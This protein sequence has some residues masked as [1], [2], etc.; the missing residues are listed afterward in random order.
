MSPLQN[1]PAQDYETYFVPILFLPWAQILLDT[2]KPQPGERLLDVACGTGIVAR[3]AAPLVGSQGKVTGVDI[4]PG[5]LNVARTFAA[6][7]GVPLEWQEGSAL[8]L[9][10]EDNSYNVIVC[11]QGLQFFP[12]KLKALQE[13]LR[14]LVPGGRVVISVNQSLAHN[15]LYN[16]FNQAFVQHL[17]APAL[18]GP[19]AFGD[20]QQLYALLV[21]AG[22]TQAAVDVVSLPIHAESRE[23][24]VRSTVYGSAAV[25]PALAQLDD[26]ARTTLIEKVIDAM[27]DPFSAYTQTGQLVFSVA[28]N[29]GYGTKLA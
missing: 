10:F 6:S 11:Q 20:D 1:N 8:S 28:A 17:G 16:V 14:V 19:F 25:V 13:M 21:E 24:F 18:A 26:A 2:A 5:M 15:A 12:D 9:P 27:K 7:G 29:I 23:A 4:N 3:Q 22:F